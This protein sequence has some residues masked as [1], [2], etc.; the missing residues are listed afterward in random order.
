[1]HVHVDLLETQKHICTRGHTGC[2]YVCTV[3][4]CLI[5]LFLK[6]INLAMQVKQEILKCL[7]DEKILSIGNNLTN[8]I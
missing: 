3:R 1:M 8:R 7:Q 4:I 2:G 5:K 6:G